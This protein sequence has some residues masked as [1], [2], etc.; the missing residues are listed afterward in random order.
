MACMLLGDL[1][2]KNPQEVLADS[3]GVIYVDG[4]YSITSTRLVTKCKL[5]TD[6]GT[7]KKKTRTFI[8]TSKT[9]IKKINEDFTKTELKGK[10]KKQMIKKMNKKNPRIQFKEKKGKVS[11]IWIWSD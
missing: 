2:F 10:K 6:N 5:E 1:T 9:K 4:K 7:L 8:L 11:T 3:V